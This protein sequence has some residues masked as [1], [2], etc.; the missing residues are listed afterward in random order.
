M[1]GMSA[2]KDYGHVMV[3]LNAYERMRGRGEI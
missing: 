1:R 3:M 2:K